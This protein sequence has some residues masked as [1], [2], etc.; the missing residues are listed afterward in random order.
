MKRIAE[1]INPLPA[2]DAVWKQK[3]Y[4]QGYFQFSFVTTKKISPLWKLK[5]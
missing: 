3:K 5:I 2:S 4:F 1:E